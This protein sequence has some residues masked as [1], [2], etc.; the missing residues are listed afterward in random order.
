N[1][2]GGIVLLHGLTDCPYS[3]KDVGEIFYEKG[4]YVVSMRLPGHGT[5][6]GAL[7]DVEWE[8]W[9][10]AVKVACG[11]VREKVGEG[12]PFYI[13]GYSNGGAVALLYALQGLEDKNLA[14]PDRLLLFSPAVGVTRFAAL[15]EWLQV[16]SF[17]P[18]FEKSRWVV[19]T[20]EYD[21][22]KYN[23]FPLNA[24]EQTY[25]LSMKV[26]AEIIRNSKNGGLSRLGAITTFQ[27][28]VDSTVIVNDLVR[29][30]YGA[31]DSGEDELVLFDVNR[32]SYLHNFFKK[33]PDELLGYLRKSGRLGYR[34]T[35]VANK[36]AS[37]N[38]VAKTKEKGDGDF[39]KE[40]S[41]GVKWPE[42]I[43]S[44]SHLAI[45]IP[46]DDLLYGFER[47]SANNEYPRLGAME[48]RGERRLLLMTA[49]NLMRLR[50]NPFFSY[51][52][53]RI[54]EIVDA[55]LD[56]TAE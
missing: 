37:S 1:P 50:S 20:P 44:L 14:A 3:L 26:K 55:D 52:K 43:Y 49:D 39:S 7:K 18:Y 11:H 9:L 36:G 41:L 8:D 22:F 2:T 5:I 33:D 29:R 31:L 34:L 15:S 27:S 23:S 17:I 40:V 19:I 42:E 56:G 47:D 48:L 28:V 13:A 54:G 10:A 24:S 53:K 4:F 38:V 35:V 32:V 45:P 25:E 16:L 6:P 51:I 30:L 12:K 46:R 21:P